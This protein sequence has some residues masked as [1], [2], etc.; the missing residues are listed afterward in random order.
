M[1]SSGRCPRAQRRRHVLGHVLGRV[2]LAEHGAGALVGG[3]EVHRRGAALERG[4]D[5]PG[6]V[7]GGVHAEADG[8]GEAHQPR[9][10]LRQVRR[11]ADAGLAQH[12]GQERHDGMRE[13]VEAAE[14]ADVEQHAVAARPSATGAPAAASVRWHGPDGGSIRSRTSALDPRPVGE[15]GRDPA[16]RAVRPTG[17]ARA[18]DV[19]AHG[20]ASSASGWPAGRRRRR[21]SPWAAQRHVRRRPRAVRRTPSHTSARPP[22]GR[23]E[24]AFSTTRVA[25]STSGTP[26]SAVRSRT[27][28]QVGEDHRAT[29]GRVACSARRTRTRRP[30]RRR[31]SRSRSASDVEVSPNAAA[32]CRGTAGV[33]A[34]VDEVRRA[35][36]GTVRCGRRHRAGRPAAGTAAP[37]RRPDATGAGRRRATAGRPAGGAARPSGRRGPRDRGVELGPRVGRRSHAPR[38]R[39]RQRGSTEPA[40][41]SLPARS[42]AGGSSATG[43]GGLG[44]LSAART[45]VAPWTGLA[46]GFVGLASRPSGDGRPPMSGLAIIRMTSASGRPVL[47]RR[48]AQVDRQV[49]RPE[50]VLELEV[51]GTED[52]R[53]LQLV[54]RPACTTRARCSAISQMLTPKLAPKL[55]IVAAL[56]AQ[57]L[58]DVARSRTPARPSARRRG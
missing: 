17:R 16:S 49:R 32:P 43:L 56:V 31:R 12:P 18:R 55:N 39:H 38:V 51:A 42:P 57:L 44:R 50:L 13:A 45:A 35:R 47:P 11:A 26:R 23:D 46:F 1:S 41:T 22:R 53:R 4:R 36:W 24:Q 29:T 21:R 19:V 33:E 8:D 40:S 28:S 37:R 10:S 15:R 34:A 2:V 52:A 5:A 14:P 9:R 27:C 25:S 7:G 3:D 58:E 20:S 54:P 30:R 48:L 6:D